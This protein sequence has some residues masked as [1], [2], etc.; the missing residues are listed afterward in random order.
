MENIQRV[1]FELGIK[2]GDVYKINN[3]RKMGLTLKISNVGTTNKLEKKF[4]LFLHSFLNKKNLVQIMSLN[5]I[6]KA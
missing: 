3:K 2:V 4:E 6:E 1:S 5:E